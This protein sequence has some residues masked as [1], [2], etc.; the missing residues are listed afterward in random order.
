MRAVHVS[1]N[2]HTPAYG[3][4][5]SFEGGRVG[6][7]AKTNK[8]NRKRFSWAF[9]LLLFPLSIGLVS[10]GSCQGWFAEYYDF[11]RFNTSVRCSRADG[12]K[13]KESKTI[14]CNFGHGIVD[15]FLNEF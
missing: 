10:V 3:W 1:A 6:K 7:A 13:K 5:C 2:L 9:R 12:L 15:I 14:Y 4:C 8:K 11:F